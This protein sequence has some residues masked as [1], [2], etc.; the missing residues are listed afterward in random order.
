MEFIDCTVSPKGYSTQG[1]NAFVGAGAHFINSLGERFMFKYH[2]SAEKGRRSDI[3]NG[4]VTETLEGR[5]PIYCDCTHLPVDEVQRLANTLGVDRPALPAFFE[6]KNIDLTKEPFEIC[7]S[8][9]ASVR[10]GQPF[11]GSGVHIDKNSASSTPGIFA[12]GDCSTTSSGIPGACVMGHIAGQSAAQFATSQTKVRPLAQE[13]LDQ[14]RETL[15]QPLQ[16]SEGMTS[17]EYEDQVREIVT[18]YVGFRRDGNRMREGLDLLRALRYKKGEMMAVDY[19]GV[20]RVNE[21]QAVQIN[22]EALAV[23]AIERKESRGGA[24]HVR[25]DYPETKDDTELRII[26]VEMVEDELKTSSKPTGLD[27]NPVQDET[28]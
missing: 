16:Q 21:A 3:I 5:G 12:G 4:W 11:R 9:I 24:A 15:Y 27:P 17:H 10:G 22:A 13:E 7:V 25:L 28:A 1:L 6:Q 20:M 23:S 2:P 8:E 19:H 26:M 18:N 14:I